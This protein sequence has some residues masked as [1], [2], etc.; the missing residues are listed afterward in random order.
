MMAI[1]M[2]ISSQKIR[3]T[4]VF[5]TLACI[6][7]IPINILQI[8]WTSKQNEQNWIEETNSVVNDELVN[9]C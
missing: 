6:N 4:E 9:D 1:P 3:L 2:Y 5:L 7:K 8:T